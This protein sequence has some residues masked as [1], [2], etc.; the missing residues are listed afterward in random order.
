MDSLDSLT[1]RS[2]NNRPLIVMSFITLIKYHDLFTKY[3][4][5]SYFEDYYKVMFA[6]PR[7]MNE[8]MTVNMS[9]DD[10]MGRHGYD[11]TP[12]HKEL[13]KVVTRG[14]K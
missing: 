1:S 11:L 6:S 9:F 3:G 12:M 2:V 5:E 7:D 10:F 8:A 13:M 14:V 4:F